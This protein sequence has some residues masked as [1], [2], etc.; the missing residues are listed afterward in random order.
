MLKKFI[1]SIIGL[2]WAGILFLAMHLGNTIVLADDFQPDAPPRLATEREL[3][4]LF[5]FS[6]KQTPERVHIV[7][8]QQ[9]VQPPKTEDQLKAQAE[10]DLKL[11]TS[12]MSKDQRSQTIQAMVADM[13]KRD[14]GDNYVK[15]EE[16]KSREMFRVDRL[17]GTDIVKLTNTTT[18]D[19]T[20]CFGID[21]TGRR[22]SWG[23]LYGIKSITF[24]YK[25]TNVYRPEG[26]WCAGYMEPN[27]YYLIFVGLADTNS[28]KGINKNTTG[29]IIID[30]HKLMTLAHG[31]N[32][33]MSIIAENGLF[34]GN[35]VCKISVLPKIPFVA[36]TDDVVLYFILDATNYNRIYRTYAANRLQ[37]SAR[38]ADREY[39]D[40]HDVPNKWIQI[41]H[42]PDGSTHTIS[43]HF[44]KNDLHPAFNDADI[45]TL[46]MP[47]N[48]IVSDVSDGGGGKYIQHPGK[49]NVAKRNIPGQIV[50][51][52]IDKRFV[53]AMLVV[54]NMAFFGAVV[55]KIKPK[56]ILRF[57]NR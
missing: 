8:V 33:L 30:E 42:M 43:T 26:L 9:T 34:K 32:Q 49:I 29:S 17:E 35:Q 22:A 31:T 18:C 39:F 38:Q 27:A 1:F 15:I 19:F 20:R 52:W 45:F 13:K 47:T 3:R 50:R 16:W 7:A 41:Q 5:E 23:T 28:L 6:K 4:S 57:F 44:L 11:D 56:H 21:T 40:G 14:S 12:L 54:L 37:K 24:D 53:I 10:A 51:S 2:F 55:F 48:Y 36:R 46:R 25:R